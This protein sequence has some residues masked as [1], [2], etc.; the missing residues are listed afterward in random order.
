MANFLFKKSYKLSNFKRIKYD[1]LWGSKGVFTTIRLFG[2]D[3]K[4]I[5]LNEHIFKLNKSLK[6]LHIPF[7]L[8]QNILFDLIPSNLRIKKYDHL[9]RVAIKKNI[10]SLSLRPRLRP[11]KNFQCTLVNY[12][13]SNPS[14]KNLQYKKILSLQKGIDMQKEEI[15]FFKNKNL[16]EGSTTN[17]IVIKNNNIFLPKGNFYRGITLD[18]ILSKIGKDY[19]NKFIKFADLESADEIILVGSGKGVVSVSSIPSIKWFSS[20]SKT[21]NRL[22]AI[23]K[24][25]LKK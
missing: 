24:K 19:S 5:F 14:I 6:K 7:S 9:L 20:S 10:L 11:K 17:L 22:L 2:K 4:Y 15:L 13:R 3:P 21:F 16:L 18:F 12:Q 8:T 1:H 23:Y 25:E